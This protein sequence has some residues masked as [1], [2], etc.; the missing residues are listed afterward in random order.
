[1]TALLSG[2]ER[3]KVPR[4]NPE[5]KRVL[6]ALPPAAK[7]RAALR[8]YYAARQLKAAGVRLLHPGW[9]DEQIRRSVRDSFAHAR[10]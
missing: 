3:A 9:S 6:A 8:L 5:Y 2:P 7:L 1:M 4:V 10:S